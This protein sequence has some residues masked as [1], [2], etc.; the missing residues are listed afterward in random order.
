MTVNGT[1]VHSNEVDVEVQFPKLDDFKYNATLY[2]AFQAMWLSTLNAATNGGRCEFGC[3]ITLDTATGQYAATTPFSGPIAGNNDGADIPYFKT[4]RPADIPQSPNPT[5]TAVYVVGFF[6]THTPMTYVTRLPPY[7]PVGPSEGD[8]KLASYAL[9]M[10]LPGLVYD[11]VG[12]ASGLLDA[13]HEL[14]ADAMLYDIKELKRR[15]TP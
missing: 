10:G 2:S 12:S 6:H 8:E 5:D 9:G 14:K 11:Y 3:Y 4:F 15:V 1:Q 13:G 7:R